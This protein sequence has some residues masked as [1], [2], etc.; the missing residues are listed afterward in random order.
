M[1]RLEGWGYDVIL[2]GGV[3]MWRSIIQADQSYSFLDYFKLNFAPQDILAFFGVELVPMSVVLPRYEGVLD[4]V[5][6]LRGRLG[7][8]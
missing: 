1:G 8:S 2:R 6:D 3:M 7:E 4:R 5:G